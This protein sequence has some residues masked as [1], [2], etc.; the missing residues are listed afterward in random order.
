MYQH[1]EGIV[2]STSTNYQRILRSPRHPHLSS[3]LQGVIIIRGTQLME[4]K[5]R[6]VVR[7]LH[8]VFSKNL[9][10]SLFIK[11]I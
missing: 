10:V 3:M 9:L 1:S 7:A 2:G 5:C 4:V 8:S 11:S 6:Q